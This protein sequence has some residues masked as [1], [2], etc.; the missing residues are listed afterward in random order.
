MKRKARSCALVLSAVFAVGEVQAE[1]GSSPLIVYATSGSN[2]PRYRFWNGTAWGGQQSANSIGAQPVW[3]V[4]R[5]CPTRF[6][7]A[8]ATV[9][10]QSDIN[11]Q[12]YSGAWGSVTELCTDTGT[13]STR[14]MDM[15]YESQSGDLLIVYWNAASGKLGY[16][17]ANALGVSS[18]SLVTLPT[19]ATADWIA[20]R[21]S[22]KSDEI[23]VLVMNNSKFLYALRWDGSGFGSVTTITSSGYSTSWQGFDAAYESAS[24]DVLLCYTVG[25]S[26]A[27]KY[28]KRSGTTWSAEASMPALSKE[29]RW[30]R[31]EPAPSG[32]SVLFGAADDDA[33]LRVCWWSGSAWG[34][35]LKLDKKVSSEMP[36]PFD[37]GF[38]PSASR[39]VVVYAESGMQ[40]MR[41]RAWN[42]SAWSAEESGC[43]VGDNLRLI[44]LRSGAGGVFGACLDE[45]RDVHEFRWDGSNLLGG[46]Q[47]TGDV[48]GD[49]N[50]RECFSICV[51]TVRAGIRIIRWREV[52]DSAP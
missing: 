36:R 34:T 23:T 35:M 15:A 8:L 4:V 32:N 17:T 49:P 7:Y 10:N 13:F 42:G 39:A 33:D 20:L 43:N 12:F 51:P 3:V 37:I 18:Q 9:D 22:V 50:N 45:G 29:A 14:C 31:L 21:P 41:R 40:V 28:R 52:Y 27:P 16:R 26:A 19:S 6:E 47:M 11:L 24:G 30:I 46:T 2:Q 1:D 25:S 44:Q 48:G 38:E 5:S